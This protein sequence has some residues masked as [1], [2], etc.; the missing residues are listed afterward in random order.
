MDR[1]ITILIAVVIAVGLYLIIHHAIVQRNTKK[2]QSAALEQT[3]VAVKAALQRLADEH[4]ISS[5]ATVLDAN[6]IPDGWGRGVMA[7]E[8]LLLIDEVTADQLPILR[9]RLNHILAEFCQDHKIPS[10]V[11]PGESAFLVT[12]AWRHTKRIHLGVAYLVNEA[13]IEYI[14]DLHRLNPKTKPVE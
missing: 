10:A 12:D 3:N 1:T 4:F 2:A 6:I 11:Q 8:Y 7:F 9:Q 13:T 14:Q 5:P